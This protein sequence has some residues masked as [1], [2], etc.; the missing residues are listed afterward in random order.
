[1]RIPHRRERPLC[2]PAEKQNKAKREQAPCSVNG[3]SAAAQWGTE[4]ADSRRVREGGLS[5]GVTVGRW[6]KKKN[7]QV[8]GAALTSTG[9]QELLNSEVVPWPRRFHSMPLPLLR[10]CWL[11]GA[12]GRGGEEEEEEAAV[13]HMCGPRHT[14]RALCAPTC[15][16]VIVITQSLSCALIGDKSHPVCLHCCVLCIYTAGWLLARLR[17][18]RAP[19]KDPDLHIS[20]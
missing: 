19:L 2:Q 15:A 5:G 11:E 3:R 17:L 18:P 13:L 6:A 8:S 20:N 16:R 1:M 10:W 14:Q 4:E 9:V 7:G 12:A